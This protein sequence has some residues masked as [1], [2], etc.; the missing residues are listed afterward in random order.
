[1]G[2]L[3]Y[4]SNT[5]TRD[6]VRDKILYFYHAKTVFRCHIVVVGVFFCGNRT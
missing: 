5:L 3:K 6:F 4:S 2:L 1:M